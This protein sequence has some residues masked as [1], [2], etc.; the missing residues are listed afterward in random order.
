MADFDAVWAHVLDNPSDTARLLVAADYLADHDADPDLE[1]GL[2]WCAAE[3]K[4][5]VGSPAD[6][7]MWLSPSSDYQPA[8][9]PDWLEARMDPLVNRHCQRWWARAARTL[10]RRTGRLV[11]EYGPAGR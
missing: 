11:L 1:A 7:F 8:R 2:R 6:G 9:I 4:W 5:P 10:V 3:G